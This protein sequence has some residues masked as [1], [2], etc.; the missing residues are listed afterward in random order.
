MKRP[1]VRKR[2]SLRLLP[3]KPAIPSSDSLWVLAASYRDAGD[4]VYNQIR[5][6]VYA[7]YAVIPCVFLYFR[8]VE[9]ALKAVLVYHGVSEVEISRS[10]GHRISALITRAENF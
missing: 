10:L 3:V 7:G 9:L 8:C 4:S 1:R 2:S 5:G 6:D